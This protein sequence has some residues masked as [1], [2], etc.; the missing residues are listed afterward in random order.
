ME[1]KQSLAGID[2]AK[3]KTVI[4]LKND[5]NAG[6]ISL[7]DAKRILK[8]KVGTL[9]PYEI[10]LAEQ[11][12]KEFDENECQ[13][14]DIQKMLELFED[15]MDTSRPD[16]PD[17]HPIMCYYRENDAL[18]KILLRLFSDFGYAEHIVVAG[19]FDKTRIDERIGKCK[20]ILF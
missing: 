3:M 9:K 10:A 5:Y 15:I 18:K 12:L 4:Q 13:K 7:T 19:F 20:P 1:M 17:A 16:L 11:E 6:K 2:E 8:E 14:E